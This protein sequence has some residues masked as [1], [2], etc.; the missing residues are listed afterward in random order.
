MKIDLV[1]GRV[2]SGYQN[3][4]SLWK[5]KASTW[6]QTNVSLHIDRVRDSGRTREI[7]AIKIWRQN[8][9]L[10][11][12]SFYLE[13]T[14][15]DALYRLGSNLAQNV[16]HV[17]NYLAEDFVG[18]VVMDPANTNNTISDDLTLVEKWA[19]ATQAKTSL[20]APWDQTLW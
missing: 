9:G 4:H 19:I 15:L 8:H 7:R 2:Q 14:V 13:L 6:T 1:P 11:F 18:A 20:T 5:H 10:D 3:W 16:Q 17:L 12:P